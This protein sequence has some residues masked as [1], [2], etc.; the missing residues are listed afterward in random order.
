M[1][2]QK[3]KWYHTMYILS[4]RSHVGLWKSL[5]K[6]K[7]NSNFAGQE[8]F[9]ISHTLTALS[10]DKAIYIQVYMS[11]VMIMSLIMVMTM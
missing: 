3:T 10:D 1:I 2:I 6:R 8:N 11:M 9:K 7:F 5:D 4:L